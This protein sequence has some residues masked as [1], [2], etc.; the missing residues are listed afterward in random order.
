MSGG[1]LCPTPRG[2]G[3]VLKSSEGDDGETQVRPAN[4]R[5]CHVVQRGKRQTRGK[6]RNSIF[7]QYRASR[8]NTVGG[9]FGPSLG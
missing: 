6:G 3:P 1:W 9:P 8:T 5:G 2:P 7:V 4:A